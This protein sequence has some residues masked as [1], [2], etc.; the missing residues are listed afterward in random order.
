VTNVDEPEQPGA[1]P[2]DGGAPAAPGDATKPK[3]ASP[4]KARDGQADIEDDALVLP[5]E[6]LVAPSVAGR[7]IYNGDIHVNN[8]NFTGSSDATGNAKTSLVPW[9]EITAG[10]GLEQP[11]FVEPPNFD[12]ISRLLRRHR[13]V[14]LTGGGC[15]NRSAAGAALYAGG[16]R[17]IVELPAGVAAQSLVETVLR[18][19]DDNPRAGILID[20]LD[21]DTIGG[22]AGYEMRRLRGALAN[23]AAVILT[24]RT[25]QG[26]SVRSPDLSAIEGV[27]PDATE[28]VR[29]V[30]R[31][32][33]ATE[34]VLA[35]AL[36]A[37]D[38]LPAP[39]GP[40][41][42][43]DL[44]EAARNNPD[45]SPEQLAGRVSWQSTPLDE[46]LREQPT[47][48]QVASLAA[49][50]SL[51]GMPRADVEGKA[52]LLEKSLEGDVEPSE[53]PRRF[54]AAAGGWPGGVVGVG[55]RVL[56]THFGRHEAEVIEICPP[57][58]RDRIVRYLWDNL[59]G[60]F[61][62]SFVDWLCDLPEHGSDRVRSGAAITAGALFVAEPMIAERELI[63]VWA[64]D[65]RRAQLACAGLTL[66]VPVALGCDP[67]PARTLAHQWVTTQNLQ[68]Q[69]VAI[70]AYGGL[71]GAWDSGSAAPSHLWKVG[72]DHRYEDNEVRDLLRRAADQSL[73]SLVAA[74]ADAGKARATVIGLIAAEIGQRP[75]RR[76]SY[77]LLPLVMRRLSAGDPVAR[78]SF[79]ALLAAPE[80]DS[81]HR[82]AGV[83][84]QAFD[85]PTGYAS[86]RTALCVLL[87]AV[88]ANRVDRDALNQLIREMKDAALPGRRS[89]LGSQI[90]RTL[91][92][93]RRRDGPRS[94]VARSVHATF[95]SAA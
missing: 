68:L 15:G 26:V 1:E 88:A 42:A 56:P 29:A 74:G 34:P 39:V 59:G 23:G 76:R 21:A 5:A 9:T 78:G 77:E 45:D 48:Q 82:L 67:T 72:F 81:L 62:G 70:A 31:A 79:T 17:P 4:P 52:A 27:P 69:R 53:E 18:V 95:Y 33:G 12:E 6:N 63:R 86:A 10:V 46:W 84:A 32:E 54:G 22:F 64:L 47:A 75:A 92:A 61:R 36:A 50:A 80:H 43:V 16:H 44:V 20:S 71:L 94:A 55:R 24:T 7:N 3:N 2:P 25:P 38:H 19:C 28:V 37:L 35:L 73:A 49:A 89:V 83:L 91:N 65:G 51:D 8:G 85:S 58:R 13:V 41:T 87:D 14:L 93:E 30:G 40:A 90:E 60:E 57:H 11:S 66:G